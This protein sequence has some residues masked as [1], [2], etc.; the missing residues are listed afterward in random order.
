[1]EDILCLKV[2]F[3]SQETLKDCQLKLANEFQK[4]SVGDL[5]GIG[6]R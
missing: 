4:C 2:L 6:I 1:V 3:R 5:F